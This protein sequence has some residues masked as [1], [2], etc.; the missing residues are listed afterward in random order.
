MVSHILRTASR[1][2]LTRRAYHIDY[3]WKRLARSFTIA[4]MYEVTLDLLDLLDLG[5]RVA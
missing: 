1:G 5:G 4:Y 2:T 3:G